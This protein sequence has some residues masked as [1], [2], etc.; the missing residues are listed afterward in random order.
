MG[1]QTDYKLIVGL[2]ESEQEIFDRVAELSGYGTRWDAEH[3]Y[4][5]KWYEWKEH[6]LQVSS[7]FPEVLL[8]LEGEGEEAGDMWHAYFKN[9]KFQ[10]CRGEVVY[11]PFDESK[12]K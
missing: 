1:Y 3:L 4:G 5:C 8:K 11:P 6:M 2:K 7:E 10:D 12:L 9:G